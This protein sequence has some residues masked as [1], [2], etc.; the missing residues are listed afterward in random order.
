MGSFMSGQARGITFAIMAFLIWGFC[1]LYFKLLGAVPAGEIL[2]H[3]ILWSCLLLLAMLVIG[4]WG[5]RV[6]AVLRTPR[7][8]AALTLSALLVAGNWLLFIWSVNNDHLLDASLGYFINPLFNIL[9]GMLFLG[10]RLRRLQWLA[11]LLALVGVLIQIVLLGHLPWIALTL[12]GT[13]ACYGLIR[14]QLPV[15]AQT[16]LFVETALL[17]PLALI[18]LGGFAHSPSSDLLANPLTLDLLLVLAGVITTVPLL[19]F[20]AGARLIPLSTLGFIQYLGPTIMFLLA[21]FYYR[22]PV[23]PTRL[24]TFCF[25]WSALLIFTAEGWIQTL[26]TS[27]ETARQN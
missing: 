20:T 13:F 22:E 18:Y 27:K 26:F 3:R 16:G 11:L 17:L 10:E 4:R 15:D 19:L 21:I 24:L 23:D 8:L 7:H 2:S 12:A 25:I 14:K 1:P 6:K 5:Y 9:L